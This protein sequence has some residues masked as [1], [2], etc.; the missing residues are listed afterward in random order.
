MFHKDLCR[1]FRDKVDPERDGA[2]DY[3][4]IIKNPMD[5]TTLRRKLIAGDY[6]T[7]EEWST[8][9][10]LIFKNARLYNEEGSLI[11]LVAREMEQWFSR[12][13]S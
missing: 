9:V 12:K 13:V 3:Y 8:D 11:D 2:K 7:I 10:N 6:K 1:P 5:L 4:E